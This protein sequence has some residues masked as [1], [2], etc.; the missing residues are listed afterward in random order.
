MTAVVSLGSNLGDR[1]ARLRRGVEVL[2]MHCAV[3]VVSAVYET[4]AVGLTDQPA[5]LNVVAFLDTAD[6]EAAFVAAQSAENSQ[7]RLRSR[8]WG[9]RSL[10]VDIIDVDGRISTDPR[11]TL[12]HP[13][14]HERA[15]VLVPWLDLDRAATL[16]GHGPV[17]RLVAGLA[18]QDVRRVA[19]RLR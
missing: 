17:R 14:A 4:A 19:D 6:P 15:F 12:P 11:L 1:G 7:G 8:R 3:Q 9:P 2:G 16:P 10:D 13:R 18:D 5:F